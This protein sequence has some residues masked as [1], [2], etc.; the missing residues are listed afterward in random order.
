MLG[1]RVKQYLAHINTK[2]KLTITTV[3]IAN[4]NIISPP[5]RCKMGYIH[6]HLL[7]GS[8]FSSI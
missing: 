3:V 5:C 2:N 4:V 6:C 7:K 8:K 1:K